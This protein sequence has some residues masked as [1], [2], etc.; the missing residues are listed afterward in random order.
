MDEET[1]KT[2]EGREIFEKCIDELKM[3]TRRYAKKQNKWTT[4]RFLGRQDREV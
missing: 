4:N 1:K 2:E 3:V